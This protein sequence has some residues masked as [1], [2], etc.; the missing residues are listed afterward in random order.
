MLSPTRVFSLCSLAILTA[1]VTWM[2]PPSCAPRREMTL[3]TWNLNW[4]HQHDHTGLNAR[5]PA[6]YRALAAYATTLNADV[7][8]LQEV[9]GPEAAM[10]VFDPKAYT[11]V[12]SSRDN[13]QRVGFAVRKSIKVT[14][15]PDLVALA[16]VDSERLRYGVD[17]TLDWGSG[18]TLRVLNVHLKSGCFTDPL[19]APQP[20][21]CPILAKQWPVLQKWVAQR[22]AEGVPF[23]IVGDFNRQLQPWDDAWRR[24]RQANPATA[25]DV[26]TMGVRSR[27]WQGRYPALIDHM[28][29]GNG[30]VV[31][32]KKDSITQLLYSPE[33]QR[34]HGMKLSDHCP[35]S[36]RFR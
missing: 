4:L 29:L 17:I 28:V 3:G 6:D 27:C 1:A 12:F 31:A 15:H 25:F 10:R 33:D 7:V 16:R 21:A 8:A 22:H 34:R 19:D 13:V 26:P 20:G 14:R 2:L 32:A 18:S 36:L 35:L 11:F 23:A 5:A 24:M 9:D 30:A